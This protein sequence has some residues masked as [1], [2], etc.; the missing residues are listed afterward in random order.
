V[1]RVLAN[2]LG[3]PGFDFE[4]SQDVLAKATATAPVLNNA[5]NA[6]LRMAGEVATPV[7]ASIYQLDGV[8]RRAPSLQLTADA[9]TAQ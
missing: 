5:S 8:V 2:L 4:T 3:V 9:R 1:I 6:P 7:V